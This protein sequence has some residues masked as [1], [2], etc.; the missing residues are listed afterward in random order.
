MTVLNKRNLSAVA[1]GKPKETLGVREAHRIM[2]GQLEYFLRGADRASGDVA[3]A[4][5]FD[6]TGTFA[7]HRASNSW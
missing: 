1:R 6:V 2:A 3:A 4:G 5:S 7:A